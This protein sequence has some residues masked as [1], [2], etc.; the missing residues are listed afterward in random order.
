VKRR[1]DPTTIPP[2]VIGD[3]DSVLKA[4][5]TSAALRELP[6]IEPATQFLSAEDPILEYVHPG[7]TPCGTLKLYHGDPR[8]LKSLAV[9]EELVSAATGTP[10][11][12][13]DLFKP[14]RPYRVHYC[15]QEDG[16]AIVRNRVKGFLRG[17]G[18][19]QPPDTVSFSVFKGIDLDSPES[20][21]KFFDEIMAAGIELL[22]LDPIR[23]F[24]AHADKGPAD[25][26]PL[27]KYF[28][29]F[30]IHKVT[31]LLT[32]HDTK[33]PVGGPD[34]RRR[35]HRASGGAWFS[36]SECPVA[37]EKVGD[38]HSLVIPE[39]FK[40]SVAPAPFTIRYHEEEN[41]QRIR[42][43]GER[44]SAEEAEA[45]AI[46]EKVLAY[47]AETPGANGNA[48]VKALHVRWGAVG[49]ALERLFRANKVDCIQK[50]RAKLWTLRNQ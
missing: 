15:S 49:D 13:L 22:A 4:D 23:S 25:V 42:L 38:G 26:M 41:G 33:P 18:I 47:L 2:E 12:G 7:L 16:S 1:P 11:Y 36:V 24:T 14:V 21:D 29:R 19:Q 37:F 6:L 39:D 20:R 45:L 5:G 43:I 34:N 46:D 17:R 8:T 28:R 30:L 27:A 48:I 50:G 9:L 10:A 44:S 40:L 35:S 32:H 31:V 3:I